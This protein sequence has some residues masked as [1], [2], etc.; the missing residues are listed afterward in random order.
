MNFSSKKELAVVVSEYGL[1]IN[2]MQHVLSIGW[3]KLKI[4]VYNYT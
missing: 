2:T 1:L 4:T 3:I